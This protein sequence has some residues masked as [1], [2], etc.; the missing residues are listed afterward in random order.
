MSVGVFLVEPLRV[1]ATDVAH[2]SAVRKAIEASYAQL[3]TQQRRAADYLLAHHRT[4][5]SLSVQDLAREAGVSEATLVR[6]ARELGYAGYFELRGALME[7]AKQ[8]LLPEDRFAFEEP[9]QEPAGAL[10]KVARNE[11]DNINRTIEEV[12]PK[13]FKR[14]VERLRRAEMVAAVGL[15]VS[16]ILARL[17][18]YLF[19]QVG[20]RAEALLRDT[21]TIGEQVERLPKKAALLVFAFQPYSKQTVDAAAR[22]AEKGITVLAITDGIHSPIVSHAQVAIFVRTENILYTN[23]I[24]GISVLLNALATELALTDKARALDQLKATSRATKDEVV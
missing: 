11:V 10:A 12:D 8:G 9:S 22:A 4:A 7:E 14:M 23:S 15:G 1:I 13:A 3:S 24:S 2:S 5:F 17:A 16:A 19:F 6:F 18:S 20:I 21:L